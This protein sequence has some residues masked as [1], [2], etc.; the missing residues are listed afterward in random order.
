MIAPVQLQHVCTQIV[1]NPYLFTEYGLCAWVTLLACCEC[2]VACIGESVR[3]YVCNTAEQHQ[4]D[5]CISGD[6]LD[7]RW[8]KDCDV[9]GLSDNKN[10]TMCRTFVQDGRLCRSQLLLTSTL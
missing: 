5:E 8:L 7:K 9:E 6:S 4:G 3:C 1:E 10:Y 2:S